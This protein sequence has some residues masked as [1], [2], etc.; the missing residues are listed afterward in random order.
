[1]NVHLKPGPEL[2]K[3][4][5]EVAEHQRF[6]ALVEEVS[7]VSEAICAA[8]PVAGQA[9]PPPAEGERGGS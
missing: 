6:A 2:E 9:V 8:R 4:Q 7:E 5:R 1:V 3:A